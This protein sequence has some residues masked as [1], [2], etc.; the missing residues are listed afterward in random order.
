[1][2]RYSFPLLALATTLGAS[3]AEPAVTKPALKEDPAATKL[4]ADARAARAEWENFP[5]F[6]ADL[7]VNLDGQIAK[8]SVTIQKTG[9]VTLKLDGHE[10]A[11][12]WAKRQLAS[13][14]GHRLSDGGGPATPCAFPDNNTT[15]PLGR[16]IQVLNDEFHSSYRIRDRQVIVV[17]RT[18]KDVRFTITVMENQV[19]AEKKF[20]PISY[21]VN[22]W[23][24]KTGALRS[25]DT[26]H[27][28]WKRI[29]ALDLPETVELVTAT[30]G[31]LEGRS[32][33]LSNYNLLAK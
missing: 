6:K 17:N 21:V 1:M 11:T 7:E 22:T 25:S 15:H 14:A 33:K 18:G 28:R 27:H 31:K 3:A 12:K 13:L 24:A 5:G 23:D 30:E 29:G 32:L 20:L 19:N 16:A 8:G 2:T 26:F 4:L 9:D 10:D